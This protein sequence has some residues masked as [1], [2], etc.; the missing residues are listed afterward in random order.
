[1]IHYAA[2]KRLLYQYNHHYQ[3]HYQMYH[4]ISFG[5]RPTPS[6]SFTQT[7]ALYPNV[8]VTT[9]KETL[10]PHRR[11]MHLLQLDQQ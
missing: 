5:C 7:P 8:F 9:R 6:S 3:Y 4:Q 2:K 11:L 10:M 1:M